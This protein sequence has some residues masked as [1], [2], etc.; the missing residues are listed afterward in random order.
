MHLSAHLVSSRI[1]RTGLHA[2]KE[3]CYCRIMVV[4]ENGGIIFRLMT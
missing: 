1:S 4:I 2:N 3:L